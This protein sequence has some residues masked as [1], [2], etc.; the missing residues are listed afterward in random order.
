MIRE[1]PRRMRYVTRLTD[2]TM[3]L[4]TAASVSSI[5]ELAGK[6]IL[7]LGENS[8][9]HVTARVL[10]DRLGIAVTFGFADWNDAIAELDAGRAGGLVI[11]DR[12]TREIGRRLAGSNGLHL[13]SVPRN[14]ALMRLYETVQIPPS[15]APGLVPEEGIESLKVPT[16]LVSYAWRPDQRRYPIVNAFLTSLLRAIPDERRNDPQSLW[17]GIDVL[18]EVEGWQRYEPIIPVIEKLSDALRLP[19]VAQSPS[20]ELTAAIETVGAP[21]TV[22]APTASAEP[23]SPTPSLK[24]PVKLLAVSQQPL[25]DAALPDGGMVTA[26]V[27]ASLTDGGSE[28]QAFRLSW[29]TDRAEQLAELAASGTYDI[30]FPWIKP[31]CDAIEAGTQPDALA[32]KL[33]GEF[34]FTAPVFQVLNVFFARRDSGFVFDSDQAVIGKALC[35]PEGADAAD[36]DRGGR[37]WLADDLVTLVRAPRLE[38][39]FRMVADGGADAVLADDFSGRTML[40]RLGLESTMAMQD[41]PVSTT[42]LHMI[43]A[44]DRPGAEALVQV[45]DERL[46]RLQAGGGYATIVTRQLSLLHGKPITD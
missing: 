16:L 43:V 14:A 1:A 3:L 25:A 23:A 4:V 11:L 22:A 6:T 10:F 40:E 37:N 41:R 38:D 35:L 34:L 44:R 32:Q 33:C 29:S 24:V 7:A 39:C 36:L 15:L 30:G 8:E 20:P 9:S 42:G 2:K 26:L 46:R 45:L 12:D 19:A 5:D 18:A 27:T 28:A 13:L 31:D 21:A 17:Q